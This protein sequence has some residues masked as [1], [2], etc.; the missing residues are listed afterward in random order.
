[1]TGS[2]RLRSVEDEDLG[3]EFIVCMACAKANYGVVGKQGV[4]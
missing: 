4:T 2:V 1:M 3:R